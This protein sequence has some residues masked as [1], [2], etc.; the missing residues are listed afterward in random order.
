[1]SVLEKSRLSGFVNR[2]AESE[3]LKMAQMARNLKA[4]GH[5]VISLSL[6][7]PD[8]DTPD[9]IKMAAIKA[10]TEGF[11]KYTPVQ[12]IAEL[13]DAISKK[14]KRDN[15][16]DYAPNQI[17]VSNG[18]KQS[19]NNVAM[20]LLEEGDECIIIAPYWV[21]YAEIIKMSGATPV[22]VSAGVEQD[23][24]VTAA[25]VE[26]AITE[27]TKMLLFSSPCNPTGAVFT[28]S[29]LRDIADVVAKYDDIYIVADEIY[30]YINYTDAGHTSI[31]SFSNV[32]ERTITV[33]GFAKGFAMTGWRL[34]YIGAPKWIADACNKIQGQVT[35][36]ANSF[37]QKAAAVA[38]TSDLEPTW[39][40]RD[41]FRKRRDMVIG[42]LSDIK[43][44]KVP[45]PEGA[46]YIF[47][48]I[49]YYFGTTDGTTLIRNADDFCDFIMTNVYV[50]LVSGS[51][52]GEPNC[53]RLSY[54][55]SEVQLREAVKRIKECCDRL[56]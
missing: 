12:G 19:I 51:A 31:G 11:T 47:P 43:G 33:N 53:F 4:Q 14:F 39:K 41:E 48:D 54:A 35:S 8:F 15:N 49:S 5:D 36:G 29:E 21:S 25:Q 23:Y 52:F 32:K 37:S 46:F 7:E 45:T 22:Y 13:T 38:L 24:K 40:M 55:A 56:R 26:A 6:G 28:K 34:G 3:T 2:I 1:M 44:F 42:L 30:E 18:A 27:R 10:L 17:V 16:L 9:H 50:G 20:A